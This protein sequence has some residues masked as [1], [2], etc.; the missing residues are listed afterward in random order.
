MSDNSIQKKDPDKNL[1]ELFEQAKQDNPEAFGRIYTMCF[2][3]VYRYIYLRVGNKAEAEDLVQLVFL[4]AYQRLANFKHLSSSPLA[5][6]FT[7]A[8]NAIIDFYRKRKTVVDNSEDLLSNIPDSR[9]SPPE[10]Y[11]QNEEIRKVLAAMPALTADQQEIIILKFIEGLENEELSR[12]TGK[13]QAAIRQIQS[14]G[15]KMLRS[16]LTKI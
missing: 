6:L 11:Q 7:I 3:P 13:S 14:R 16:L 4:K 5:Y 2:A 10:E 1:V 12:I 8:R 9:A 15:L